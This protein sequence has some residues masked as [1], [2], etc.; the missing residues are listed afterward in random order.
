MKLEFGVV[1]EVGGTR[2][3]REERS[4]GQT[5]AHRGCHP[6]EFR[7]HL[8]VAGDSSRWTGKRGDGGVSVSNSGASVSGQVTGCESPWEKQ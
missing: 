2:G 1:E 4:D 3:R 6:R 8:Q 5:M 7:L